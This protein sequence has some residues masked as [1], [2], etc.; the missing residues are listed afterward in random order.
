MKKFPVYLALLTLLF[1]MA[2]AA[3]SL[4]DRLLEAEAEINTLKEDLKTTKSLAEQERANA[5]NPSIS[6]IG[7]ILGQYGFG[8]KAHDHGHDHDHDHD[9]DHHHGHDEFSNGV[10]VREL[11]L[12]FRGDISPDFDS[13]IA[14]AL[15]QHGMDDVHVHIE[16]AYARFKG[17]PVHIKAG[18]FKTAIG[19][20]NRLHLHNYPQITAP[21]ALKTFLGEEGYASQ[22]LSFAWSHAFSEKTALS[23]F[24]EGVMGN[25]VPLQDEGAEEMPNGIAHAWFHQ[26]LSAAHFLDLGASSLLGRQGAKKSGAFWLFGGDVH[27][28]YIP[29]GYGQDPIFLFGLESFFAK[30]AGKKM[31]PGGFTWAQTKLI[32][33]SFLGLRYDLAPEREEDHYQ[34]ALGAYLGYYATEFLRLRFGYEH[35]MPSL[36]SLEGDHRFMLSLS[37]VL[38]SHPVEPYYANR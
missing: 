27:Y 21:L 31:M 34:H 1:K 13:L 3:P 25:H 15:A 35:V 22:G 19:R 17:W 11:E 20:M 36:K 6:V 18:R 9:H 24:L 16:E 10:F 33:S 4:E 32:G 12:E 23:L 5:F 37:F 2:H 30:P 14:I 8:K 7:D 29:T 28:S 26:E 38:G